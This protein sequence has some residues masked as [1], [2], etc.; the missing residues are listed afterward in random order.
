VNRLEDIIF[1]KNGG[2]TKI[3]GIA[4]KPNLFSIKCNLKQLAKNSNGGVINYVW[5]FLSVS[6]QNEKDKEKTRSCISLFPKETIHLD[7]QSVRRIKVDGTG[8]LA[9]ITEGR[10]RVL[11]ADL[12]QM[13]IIKVWKGVRDCWMTFYQCESMKYAILYSSTRGLLEIYRMRHGCK[14]YSGYIESDL[15]LFEL[16]MPTIFS[17]SNCSLYSIE[18]E[19]HY[20]EVKD[21]EEY[22]K[23]IYMEEYMLNNSDVKEH[24]IIKDIVRLLKADSPILNKEYLKSTIGHLTSASVL[25]GLYENV[26]E[27]SRR[28]DIT[29]WIIEEIS[30][31]LDNQVKQ[32]PTEGEIIK[33]IK[34]VIKKKRKLLTLYV[35]IETAITKQTATCTNTELGQW[36]LFYD[37]ILQRVTTT[38]HDTNLLPW[39]EFITNIEKEQWDGNIMIKTLK[40]TDKILNDLVINFNIPLTK[41]FDWFITW[42]YSVCGTNSCHYPKC[43]LWEMCRTKE[44]SMMNWLMEICKE[45]EH[46]NKLKEYCLKCPNILHVV[47]ISNMLKCINSE[48]FE[49][50]EIIAKF[51][52]LV[53][54]NVN[55][56]TLPQEPFMLEGKISIYEYV[57]QC[58]IDNLGKNSYQADILCFNARESWNS[59]KLE[60]SL[61]L[62]KKYKTFEEYLQEKNQKAPYKDFIFLLFKTTELPDTVKDLLTFGRLWSYVN[63]WATKCDKDFMTQVT[64]Q[65]RHI[66][67]KLLRIPIFLHIW[68]TVLGPKLMQK[69]INNDKLNLTKGALVKLLEL[70]NQFINDVRT[71]ESSIGKYIFDNKIKVIEYKEPLLKMIIKREFKVVFYKG[72]KEEEKLDALHNML[73]VSPIKDIKEVVYKE[74]SSYLKYYEDCEFTSTEEDPLR[75]SLDDNVFFSSSVSIIALVLIILHAEQKIYKK[76]HHKV[77][78]VLNVSSACLKDIFSLKDLDTKKVWNEIKNPNPESSKCRESFLREYL[79]IDFLNAQD[80]CKKL[81]VNSEK[82]I[83]DIIKND[84]H[85]GNDKSLKDNLFLI[86]NN[87]T[88][89]QL[90]VNLFKERIANYLIST[91]NNAVIDILKLQP[92]LENSSSFNH[93]DSIESINSTFKVLKEK[94]D[95][96]SI[97]ILEDIIR[98]INTN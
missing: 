27:I 5:S 4:K 71:I 29:L 73:Y 3:V 57:G 84:I 31:K 50:I 40:S 60:F 32:N 15:K 16:S 54:S 55:Y 9:L 51:Y 34:E 25:Y 69:I 70:L 43:K 89:S 17:E 95:S 24:T 65:Y 75:A 79:V 7:Y 2:I 64:A 52:L 68:K 21:D 74:V 41:Q 98:T 11:L 92:Y 59:D 8:S 26:I 38:E 97:D 86:K 19:S 61:D 77:E 62:N 48:E 94:I 30:N 66:D 76:V 39:K 42:V 23:K 56:T 18:L 96:K 6:A 93:K 46:L 80:I 35:D 28:G 87:E 72:F 44:C 63:K 36:L 10:G 58:L 37:Y 20:S 22:L 85:T 1:Y 12:D 13:I 78:D 14:L 90:V 88:L 82:I 45:G 91:N 33:N 67:N 83:G 53:L 81:N 47:F 49:E